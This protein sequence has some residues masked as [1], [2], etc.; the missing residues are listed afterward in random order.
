MSATVVSDAFEVVEV[1]VLLVTAETVVSCALVDVDSP[2]VVSYGLVVV[3]ARMVL[4]ETV[5]SPAVVSYGLVL[6]VE[7]STDKVV[8]VD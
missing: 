7:V 5:D 3:S 8:F 6:C 4:A 1:S 2:I